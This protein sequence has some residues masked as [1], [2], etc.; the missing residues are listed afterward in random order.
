MSPES[1][2]FEKVSK[3]S[4]IWSYGV[5][6]WEIFSYGC[7]PYPSIEQ[8]EIFEKLKSGYRMERP[9]ACRPEIYERVI[10][11]CWNMDPKN[12]PSFNQIIDI[13][14][15]FLALP[16]YQSVN[17][18]LESKKR[19]IEI[20]EDKY[21]EMTPKSRASECSEY[22]KN[23]RLHPSNYWLS[24]STS[25]FNPSNLTH[26]TSSSL[27]T[28]HSDVNKQTQNLYNLK[29]NEI[30]IELG[31][32]L[33]EKDSSN[34]ENNFKILYFTENTLENPIYGGKL[35]NLDE[36]K[37]NIKK[38][39]IIAHNKFPNSNWINLFKSLTKSNNKSI[40]TDV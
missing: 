3:E 16:E 39:A 23:T 38:D 34:Q 12:R 9:D 4:D 21:F 30:E 13:F 18:H 11:Q 10:K 5:L 2:S 8:E 24:T 27:S 35:I 40:V 36:E 6:V 37:F 17:M 7:T 22:Q 26:T 33:L 25:S 1:L 29:A 15:E 31:K 14:A 20:H 32:P 28:S 19:E